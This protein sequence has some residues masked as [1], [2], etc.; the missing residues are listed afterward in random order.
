M[1]THSSQQMTPEAE[2]LCESAPEWLQRVQD[3]PLIPHPVGIWDWQ[4]THFPEY[5]QV[6]DAV[7]Q[8]QALDATHRR[9]WLDS[10]SVSEECLTELY[11]RMYF[12]D[13]QIPPEQPEIL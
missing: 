5:W 12:T 13:A 8:F 1:K 11:N 3:M 4:Q 7:K 9:A 2:H 10:H 6:S